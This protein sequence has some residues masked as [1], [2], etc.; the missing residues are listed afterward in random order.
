MARSLQSHGSKCEHATDDSG[1]NVHRSDMH[2]G[3]DGDGRP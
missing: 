1:L 2:R 3:G